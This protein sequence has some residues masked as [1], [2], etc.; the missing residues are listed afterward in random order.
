VLTSLRATFGVVDAQPCKKNAA[1]TT[2]ARIF[3]I[4]VSLRLWWW[5]YGWLPAL[6]L[7]GTERTV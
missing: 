6:L 4:G 5:E 3:V 1:T 7:Y 2:K